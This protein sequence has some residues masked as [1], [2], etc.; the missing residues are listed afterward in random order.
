MTIV[1]SQA[2]EIIVYED[3]KCLSFYRAYELQA[4]DRDSQSCTRLG[5]DFGSVRESLLRVIIAR[6]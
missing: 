4:N 2:V 1:C 6:S 5:R 3:R